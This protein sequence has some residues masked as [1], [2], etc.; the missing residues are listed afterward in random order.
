VKY[1][2]LEQVPLEVR[3]KVAEKVF[4][5]R[6][7]GNQYYKCADGMCVWGAILSELGRLEENDGGMPT[8]GIIAQRL[9]VPILAR[10]MTGSFTQKYRQILDIVKMNDSGKLATREAVRAL[11]LGEDTK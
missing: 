8:A 3:E 5:R 7:G 10:S 6:V 1:T 4:D 9:G 2:V 11:L